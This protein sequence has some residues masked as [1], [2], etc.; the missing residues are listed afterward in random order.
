V[1]LLT[2]TGRKSGNTYT[3]PVSYVRE[4]DTITIFSGI[5]RW[6]RNLRGG[7]PVAVLLQGRRRTGRAEV[8]EEGE[9]LVA[10]AEHLVERYGPKGAGWRIGVVLD[11]APS[12]EDLARAMEGHA[13]IRVPLDA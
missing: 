9:A 12:R 8:I 11:E 10:E 1:L 6:W 5:H 13:V 7:G 2:Y 3:L 4:G